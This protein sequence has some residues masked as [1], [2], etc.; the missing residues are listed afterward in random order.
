MIITT[1]MPAERQSATASGT[2]GRSGS[3]RPTRPEELEIEIRAAV[4]PSR[5]RHGE[6][7]RNTQHAQTLGRHRIHRSRHV[8]RRSS[9]IQM[10]QVRDGFRRALGGDDGDCCRSAGL[11]D[12]RHGEQLGTKPIGMQQLPVGALHGLR[13][14]QSLAARGRE[15]PFPSGRTELVALASTPNSIRSRKPAGI[16]ASG[17]SSRTKLA[18]SA[19][20]SSAID[21]RFS[22]S[23][24]VLSVHST[25]A[26]PS[27]SIAAARRVRTRACEMRQAPMAMNTVST[28]GNSS[29][30]I[31]MPSAMPPSTAS[32]HP[33]RSRP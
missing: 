9:G 13:A 32:S 30:S 14:G 2:L 15:T 24:P 5:R 8:R 22:V 29:G 17:A 18:P 4:R 12:M 33:P 31:D 21:I 7:A 1:L 11:P 25:V 6:R 3:A 27:V 23:V 28:T 26:E 16:A 20:R 19:V 10:A